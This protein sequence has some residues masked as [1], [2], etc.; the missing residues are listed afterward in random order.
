MTF[1]GRATAGS[2]DYFPPLVMSV[3]ALAK[4]RIAFDH[5]FFDLFSIIAFCLLIRYSGYTL[6]CEI[7]APL[8][9]RE[10]LLEPYFL[11]VVMA[12]AAQAGPF[13]QFLEEASCSC[14]TL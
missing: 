5:I 11:L 4:D 13:L 7:E 1:L 2:D 8:I 14:G 3:P 12:A 6:R 9:T 10:V